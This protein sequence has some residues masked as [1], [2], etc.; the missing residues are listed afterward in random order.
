M[1]HQSLSSSWCYFLFSLPLCLTMYRYS[2][3]KLDFDNSPFFFYLEKRTQH[4]SH[5]HSHARRSV[6]EDQGKSKDSSKRLYQMLARRNILTR[7]RR[8][9]MTGPRKWFKG[10]LGPHLKV[11]DAYDSWGVWKIIFSSLDRTFLVL[12]RKLSNDFS[13][14]PSFISMPKRWDIWVQKLFKILF[15]LDW[16]VTSKF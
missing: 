14:H 6:H 2:K 9:L 10:T 5:S 3:E 8:E 11:T 7:R 13:I 16:L 12:N 1:V 4:K 15:L